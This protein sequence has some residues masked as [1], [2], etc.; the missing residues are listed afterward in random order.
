ML[1]DWRRAAAALV[2]AATVGLTGCGFNADTLQPYTQADGANVEAG[3]VKVRDLV[4]VLDGEGEAFLT[5]QIIADADDELVE[6]TGQAIGYDNQPAG[7]LSVDFDQ[8]ELTANEP[9]NLLSTPIRLTSDELAVGSTVRLTLVF[10]SGAQAEV[11]A[12]VHSADDAVYGS[13]SPQAP[14]ASPRG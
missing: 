1:K 9:A 14:S 13:A 8:I 2:C 5:G 4:A 7:Q 12:P 10:A 11:V 6:V 3:D